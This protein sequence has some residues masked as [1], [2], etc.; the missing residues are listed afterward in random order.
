MH[1]T[2]GCARH[3][4]FELT[5]VYIGNTIE[6]TGNES[7][8]VK[9][10]Y[11]GGQRVA[12]RKGTGAVTYLFG[13]H[14]GSTSK[15]YTRNSDN[16]IAVTEQRYYPWGGTRYSSGGAA[17]TAFQYTGQR[18]DS[19]IGLYFYN[20]RYYDPALGRFLQAD[21]IVP[22]FSDP[23]S[24]NRYSYVYNNPFKYVDSN[25]HFP[26]II[27]GGLIGMGVA[28]GSQVVGNMNAGMDFGAALTT[29]I[30]PGQIVAGGMI[31]MAI[32][33]GVGILA[34]VATTLIGGG[35]TAT[36][37]EAAATAGATL[38]TAELTD[39]DDDEARIARIA[40]DTNALINGI[41]GGEAQAVDQAL[42]GRIPVVSPAAAEEFMRNGDANALTGFLAER[43][44]VIGS[45][46][47]QQMV[48]NLQEQARGLG[49]VLHDFDA[50]IVASA[51]QDNIPLLTRDTRL[52]RFLNAINIPVETY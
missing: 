16:T 43:G 7:T 10:Y 23:Q 9:Y 24:L 41:E 18:N 26:W 48:N 47:T 30:D 52:I 13:D 36:T 49:R 29:N 46:G 4:C 19:S 15:T 11:A 33:T 42:A 45:N 3:Y 25:G 40:L 51:I 50:R 28:Y 44:G 31:G 2:G 17:P 37:V 34:P 22:N 12:M 5:T 39:G 14:L 6:W 21:T 32:G 38:L 35:A 8:M 1:D 20:A 27:A